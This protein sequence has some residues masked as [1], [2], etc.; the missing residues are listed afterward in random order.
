[1]RPDGSIG[2]DPGFVIVDGWGVIRGD[3]RYQTL[4]DDADKLTRHLGLLATEIRYA[5]GPGA[6]AYEAAHLFLC[7]P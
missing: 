3:Y 2:F 4:S 7:Y 1:V 5:S 6:I